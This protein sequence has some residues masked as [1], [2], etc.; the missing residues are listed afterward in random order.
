MS[1]TSAR[2]MKRGDLLPPLIVDLTQA[3]GTPVPVEDAEVVLIVRGVHGTVIVDRAPVIVTATEDAVR[4]TYWWQPGD[5]DIA[6][7]YRGEIEVRYASGVPVTVPSTGYI[8][9]VIEADLG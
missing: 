8:L 3:D 6:G 1:I 5:T 2:R 7:N 9:L 4:A